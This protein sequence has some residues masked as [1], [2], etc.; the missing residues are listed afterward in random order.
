MKLIVLF[1]ILRGKIK[2][3]SFKLTIDRQAR[4]SKQFFENILKVPFLVDPGVVDYIDYK[5]T[6]I[7][8][9]YKKSFWFRK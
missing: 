5:P 4:V 3:W 7:I 2:T 8:V 6:T 9:N 1:N